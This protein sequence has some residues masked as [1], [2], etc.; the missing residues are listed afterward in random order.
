M[1][2]YNN[3]LDDV[4]RS[5]QRADRPHVVK[6]G[7]ISELAAMGSS[8]KSNSDYRSFRAMT[9]DDNDIDTE[10]ASTRSKRR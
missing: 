6:Q 8:M 7:G 5:I 3:L 10:E 4:Q 9:E 2:Y 1:D